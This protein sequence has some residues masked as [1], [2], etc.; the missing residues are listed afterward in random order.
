MKPANIAGFFISRFA[1]MSNLYLRERFFV[2][3]RAHVHARKRE[4][5]Q[6]ANIIAD[7]F[8]HVARAFPRLRIFMRANAM[9]ALQMRLRRELFLTPPI[10][11]LASPSL[12]GYG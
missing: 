10:L 5:T 6:L 3:P 11:P 8:A 1:M 7:S 12:G 9:K 2:M 4:V